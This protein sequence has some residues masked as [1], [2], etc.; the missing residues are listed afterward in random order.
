MAV[1][2]EDQVKDHYEARYDR[3]GGDVPSD[4]VKD[5]SYAIRDAKET[6]RAQNDEASAKEPPASNSDEDLCEP[7]CDEPWASSPKEKLWADKHTASD[8]AMVM[9]SQD[10]IEDRTRDAK[11]EEGLTQETGQRSVWR[12]VIGHPG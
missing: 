9:D 11:Y 8:E 12:T 1:T 4:D 7:F 5:D 6:V 3:I 10:P 2:A